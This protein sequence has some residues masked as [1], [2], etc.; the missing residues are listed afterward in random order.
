METDLYKKIPVKKKDIGIFTRVFVG[1]SGLKYG[2]IFFLP[3]AFLFGV[4]VSAT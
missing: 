1:I 4:E 2:S 3:V